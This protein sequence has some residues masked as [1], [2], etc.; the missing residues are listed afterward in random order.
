MNIVR[1]LTISY[2]LILLNKT[3]IE[4]YRFYRMKIRLVASANSA[5]VCER[6]DF[7]SVKWTFKFAWVLSTLW[8]SL[9]QTLIVLRESG[10]GSPRV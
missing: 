4:D 10:L 5:T 7:L 8:E 6:L 3:E 2:L 9:N 1:F